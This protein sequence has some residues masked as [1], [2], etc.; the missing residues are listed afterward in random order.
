MSC[1]LA[2]ATSF[3]PQGGSPIVSP[4]STRSSPASLFEDSA[5]ETELHTIVYDQGLIHI[6]QVSIG[7]YS[8][9]VYWEERQK[10]TTPAASPRSTRSSQASLF[11]DSADETEL[12]TIVYDQGLIHISQGFIGDYSHVVYWEERQKS[13]TPAASPRSTRSSQASLFEDSADETELHTIV[14]DQG[15]EERQ[16]ST[17]P[18]ASP[19]STR[20]SQASLFEDS[21]DET[22]LHTIG[23]DQ[24]LAQSLLDDSSELADSKNISKTGNVTIPETPEGSDES[25]SDEEIITVKGKGK[26]NTKRK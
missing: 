1:Y 16:K 26:G 22:E 21:A 17:T 5:N 18:A 19:R 8:H 13:T 3:T 9:V 12:H 11:E 23:Y 10:S 15:L 25:E 14:Y 20:C 7:A 2:P 6:S 24:G 4:R